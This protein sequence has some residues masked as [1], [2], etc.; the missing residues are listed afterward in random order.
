[1]SDHFQGAVETR[2]GGDRISRRVLAR[3]AVW[4]VPAVAVVSA[5]PAMAASCFGCYSFDFASLA[6]GTSFQNASHV[7]TA[8][9]ISGSVSCPVPTLTIG[10]TATGTAG[11]PTAATCSTGMYSSAHHLKIGTDGEYVN[12]TQVLTWHLDCAGA[13]IPNELIL[14]IGQDATTSVTFTFSVPVHNLSFGVCDL[15]RNVDPP[16]YQTYADVLSFSRPVQ[17]TVGDTTNLIHSPT[18]TGAGGTAAPVGT[19]VP[20]GDYLFRSTYGGGGSS[21]TL[22]TPT[23]DWFTTFTLQY[24]APISCGWQGLAIRDLAFCGGS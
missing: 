8:T 11:T 6:A 7:V 3:G 10:G 5:A 22:T 14:N 18:P 1:M 19:I 12:A 4:A 20:T 17:I 23:A 15:S 21:L 9:R 2:V 24:V 13:P 16:N